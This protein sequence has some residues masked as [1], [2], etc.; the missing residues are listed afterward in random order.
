MCRRKKS[1]L[2]AGDSEERELARKEDIHTGIELFVG[3][4]FT[5]G[6]SLQIIAIVIISVWTYA[7]A[8]K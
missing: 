2:C 4:L 6:N 7:F 3:C 8:Q 5:A 1:N